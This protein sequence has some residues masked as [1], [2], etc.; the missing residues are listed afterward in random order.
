[1]DVLNNL[2]VAISDSCNADL[3]AKFLPKKVNFSSSEDISAFFEASDKDFSLLIFEN[4]SLKEEILSKIITL[5]GDFSMLYSE[6]YDNINKKV[7]LCDY[8]DGSLRDDFDFGKCIIVNNAKAKEAVKAQKEKLFH[9]GLYDFRLKISRL[10]KILKTESFYTLYN[11]GNSSEDFETAH[12]A[13][14]DPKNRDY[15]IEAE[16]VFTQYLETINAKIPPVNTEV[17][18]F[19][20]LVKTFKT[21]A[22]IIIPVK[23]RPDTILTA[24]NSALNQ[25]TNFPFNVIVVDNHSESL[26]TGKIRSIKNPAL[27]HI[28]PEET[29]LGIGGC[30]NKAINSPYCGA[31]AVQLDSDD[32]YSS[33]DVLQKI[34]DVFLREKCGVVIGSYRLTDFQ[35]RPLNDIIIDHREYTKEN[36][37]NNALRVNGFGAPRC[38]FTPIIRENPFENLSYGED[39]DL[40][41]RLSRQ[42]KLERI[43]DVL[44]LCRR[45]SGNS[46]AGLSL[47]AMVKNNTLKDSLRTRELKLRIS[48]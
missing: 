10:G 18:D 45:W 40:C 36:G 5:S 30:W 17:K 41:L 38:Y 14:C 2:N 47:E 22:S 32:V 37:V 1:M 27:V 42:Y 23:N 4:I 39:Y 26:T 3:Y 33:D 29:D 8:L 9:A 13:Y 16:K 24:I 6:Y 44:Y 19:D 35:M 11:S 34:V 12:F 28:I 46:D 43:F 20:L 31:F 7:P 15:Q 48:K 21:L 25:K